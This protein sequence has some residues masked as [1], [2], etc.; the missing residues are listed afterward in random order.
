MD[1]SISASDRTKQHPVYERMVADCEVG[2]LGAIVCYN[3]DRFTRQPCELEDWI[4]HAE[5]RR[6]LLITVNGDVDLSV[7][8]GRVY[9]KIKAAVVCV[10]VER[11]GTRRRAPGPSYRIN[12]EVI[13]VLFRSQKWTTFSGILSQ[14]KPV[15]ISTAS[16]GRRSQCPSSAQF[17]AV[18]VRRC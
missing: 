12:G 8:G 9:T 15:L 18:A 3:L 17:E 6:L 16:P 1:Q 10:E 13:L 5:S 2:F 7:D 4:D 14:K 11:Q